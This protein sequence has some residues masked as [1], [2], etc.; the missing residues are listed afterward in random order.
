M[1]RNVATLA[2]GQVLEVV[3]RYPGSRA[4]ILDW[5][6]RTGHL[7]LFVLERGEE[8]LFWIRKQ[9]AGGAGMLPIHEASLLQMN[10]Q[11]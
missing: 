6:R 4:E 3:S 1:Y 10:R 8:T 7:L 5:C 2:D 11:R 9:A